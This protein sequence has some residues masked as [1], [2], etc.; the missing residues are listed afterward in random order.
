MNTQTPRRLAFN[1]LVVV[2]FAFMLLPVVAVSYVSFFDSQ[3]LTFPP[4]GYTLK[5]FANVFSQRAFVEGFVTSAKIA[6]L[7][8]VVGVSVGLAIAVALTRF[9][10]PGKGV[11]MNIMLAPLLVP[12]IV[13]G[14]ALYV[15]FIQM[16]IIWQWDALSSLTGLVLAH[17]TL[18][19][20]WSVRLIVSSMGMLDRS[21]EEAA[22]NL[23]AS[24]WTTF[25]RITLPRARAGIVAASMF[26]FIVSFENLEVSVLLVTP[27]QTTLPIAMLEYLE[28]Q[29]DPT[30]A[31]ASTL[32]ILVIGTLLL[33]TDR[34]V[35]LSR[36]V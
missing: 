32:Q 4:E 35:K 10:F 18:T 22:R 31:A 21:V 9:D 28:W 1:F 33:V 11:I 14:T 12:G 7:A 24:A 5:W 16:S 36:I 20:P 6:F 29:M 8:M 17:I 30:L 23:G 34:F 27:G 25:W 15:F 19:I 3:F 26:S 2:I 13:I